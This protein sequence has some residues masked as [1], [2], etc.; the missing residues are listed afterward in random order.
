VDGILGLVFR[1]IFVLPMP[2]RPFYFCILPDINREKIGDK[3]NRD[4]GFMELIVIV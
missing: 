4:H 2:N 1:R 3:L